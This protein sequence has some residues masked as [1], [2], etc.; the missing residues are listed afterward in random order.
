MTTTIEKTTMANNGATIVHIISS[1]FSNLFK[2]VDDT[3]PEMIIGI[4]ILLDYR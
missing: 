4:S 1:I 2:M 3:V